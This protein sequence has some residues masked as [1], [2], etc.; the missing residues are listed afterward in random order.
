MT[1]LTTKEEERKE[2]DDAQVTSV[3]ESAGGFELGA[4]CLWANSRSTN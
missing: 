2:K 3:F 1:F 4:R